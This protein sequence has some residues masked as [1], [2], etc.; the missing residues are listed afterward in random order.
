M[1]GSGSEVYTEY[2]RLNDETYPTA[3]PDGYGFEEVTMPYGTYPTAL[4]DGYGF[5]DYY[6]IYQPNEATRNN[7]YY[8]Q[9]VSFE[10]PVAILVVALTIG[11]VL[12]ILTCVGTCLCCTCTTSKTCCGFQF[13]RDG[14]RDVML[15]MTNFLL[16]EF[17]HTKSSSGEHIYT[18]YGVR[19]SVH[20]LYFLFILLVSIIF[21]CMISF[22]N[23]FLSEATL[24]QCN[25]T[26]DCFPINRATGHLIRVQPIENCTDFEIDETNTVVCFE[27][28]YRYSKG[29][30]EAGGF[31]FSMQAITNIFIYI[32][33]RTIRTILK[34]AKILIY[35]CSSDPT[36][37]QMKNKVICVSIFAKLLAI[38]IVQASYVV[39][40]I[41]I[42]IWFV[43]LRTDF[44]TTLRTPQRKLQLGLYI[45]TVSLLF[46]VP[47][48]VGIF[49]QGYNVYEDID[50]DM[51]MN[52]KQEID[53]EISNYDNHEMNVNGRQAIEMVSSV[54]EN[55]ESVEVIIANDEAVYAKGGQEIEITFEDN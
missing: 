45:Y 32:V 15:R 7:F 31:L 24:D 44:Q 4:P 38:L 52:E 35:K 36:N 49:I 14:L 27:V 30:G 55:F 8:H 5:E 11:I 22:W 37:K 16:F 41:V 50:V 17:E 28:V 47:L 9:S 2:D 25:P 23:T 26:A 33:V 43:V 10:L 21:V 12:V 51:Y 42:P 1:T 19:V 39:M 48:F 46:M 29:L 18:L 40:L 34:I 3:L 13:I 20:A 6:G 53:P 54:R